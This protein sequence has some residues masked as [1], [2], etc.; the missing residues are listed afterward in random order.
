[1]RVQ[2]RDASGWNFGQCVLLLLFLAFF[3][4]ASQWCAAETDAVPKRKLVNHTEVSYPS[5]ARSMALASVVRVD[6][7]VAP[8]H[9]ENGEYQGRPSSPGASRHEHG[10]AMEVGE[11][12]PHESHEL[13]EIRFTPRS[14]TSI[15]IGT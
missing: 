2:A 5:L 8:D 12:S 9:R 6:A 7:V 3:P 13:V 4:P 1:M 11:P 14:R 15:S 10:P